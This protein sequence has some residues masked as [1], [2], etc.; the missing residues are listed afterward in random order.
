MFECKK[1]SMFG[2]VGSMNRNILHAM[3]DPDFSVGT[4]K[5]YGQKC[6]SKSSSVTEHARWTNQSGL[7]I[8]FIKP[9]P[10]SQTIKSKAGRLKPEIIY[11]MI[12]YMCFFLNWT[13]PYCFS[14]VDS[15]LF[16]SRSE[17][18]STGA[19]VLVHSL[20]LVQ[21][22]CS[23]RIN[24]HHCFRKIHSEAVIMNAISTGFML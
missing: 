21:K 22:L 4:R 5:Q 3:T 16:S 10:S 24:H 12:F 1:W 19:T 13:L 9:I 11:V 23:G 2:T 7:S 17:G 14:C 20:P 6:S 8:Q 18:S 15:I